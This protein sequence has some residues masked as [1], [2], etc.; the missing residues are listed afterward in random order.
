MNQFAEVSA[1][2]SSWLAQR[3]THAGQQEPLLKTGRD[4]EPSMRICAYVH[5]AYV[6]TYVRAPTHKT[7]ATPEVRT[8]TY[9]HTYIETQGEIEA[10]TLR[11]F[12]S[13]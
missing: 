5:H 10:H 4:T 7:R 1:R 13:R 3:A 11:L 2:S 6:R 9:I 12:A 8:Y